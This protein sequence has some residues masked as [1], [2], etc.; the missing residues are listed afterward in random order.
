[1]CVVIVAVVAVLVVVKTA[2]S[3]QEGSGTH[4]LFLH[5]CKN[6]VRRHSNLRNTMS[7]KLE[8]VVD[9]DVLHSIKSLRSPIHTHTHTKNKKCVFHPVPH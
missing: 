6:V 5:T 9:R 8:A 3:V 2:R 1:M 4:C 7:V